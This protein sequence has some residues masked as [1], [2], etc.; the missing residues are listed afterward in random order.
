[1]A[2]RKSTKRAREGKRAKVKGSTAQ[3]FQV[4][5]PYLTINGAKE[6]IEWYRKVWGAKQGN[7]A[8]TPDGKI[9]HAEIKIGNTAV[10]LSDLF[11][12][13]GA[14]DPKTLEDT[15]VALHIITPKVDQLWN[16]A[17]AAGAKVHMPLDDQFWGDRYGQLRDPFGHYWSL[18]WKSKLPKSELKKKQEEAMR[19]FAGGQHPGQ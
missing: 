7:V 12:W 11:E 10:F 17:I 1:M 3:K 19:M 5:T 9:M 6:A 13:S 18:S 2:S 15:G 14:K 8:P 16:N 4:V